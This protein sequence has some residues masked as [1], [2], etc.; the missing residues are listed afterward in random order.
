M[1]SRC[2][3]PYRAYSI[4]FNSANNDEFFR[5]WILKDCIEV[6]EKK[7]KLLSCVNVFVDVVDVQRWQR[8]VHTSGWHASL[9]LK[10]SL[11]NAIDQ[12]FKLVKLITHYIPSKFNF[13]KRR[14]N[15]LYLLV[16][17]FNSS[18]ASKAR[19]F[20]EP[21]LIHWIKVGVWIN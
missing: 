5:S 9:R 18:L 15:L 12:T 3:K 16:Q 6:Q 20:H 11:K 10:H 7:R 21:S 19:T 8:I 17:G 2:F 13:V 1:N 14:T 4:S